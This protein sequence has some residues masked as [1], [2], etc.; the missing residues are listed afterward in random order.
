M[1]SRL[2]VHFIIGGALILA[3]SCVVFA[4]GGGSQSELSPLQR[5][6]VM[7]SKLDSMRRSLNS[8]IAALDAQSGKSD[9]DK[10]NLDDPAQRLRGLDRDV[11]TLLSEVNDL[12]GKQERAER[13]DQTALDR[14]ETAVK[15]L[16]TRVQGGLQSTAASRAASATAGTTKQPKKKKGKFLGLFGG[17]DNDKYEELT[18][19]VAPGRDRVLF[20]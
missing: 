11:G 1:Y 5:L 2:R 16:D 10:K 20:E 6:D 13:Y 8:A 17:G 15:E 12:R 3:L 9:K 18:G 4:Q 7:R 14:L 19:T